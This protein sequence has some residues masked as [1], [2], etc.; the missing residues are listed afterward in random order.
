ML[1]GKSFEDVER[2]D[3]TR[4]AFERYLEILCEAVRHLP[5]EWK[6]EHPQIP[7]QNIAGLG[8]VLRH[9]YDRVD[10]PT[11]WAIY[12]RDLDPLERAIDAMLAAHPLKD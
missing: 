7:W 8:N 4:A 3:D 6:S 9:A 11:L 2:D 12:E 10:L 1:S 5:G